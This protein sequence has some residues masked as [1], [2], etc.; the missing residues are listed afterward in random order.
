MNLIG[1][2]ADVKREEIED[3][4][5]IK[6]FG[7]IPADENLALSCLNEGVPVVL[8]NPRHPIAKAYEE[9]AR[10]LVKVIQDMNADYLAK[11]KS[12]STE[13]LKKTS[14]LG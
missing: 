8:K 10:S 5:K 11:M 7:R 3:L 4:L 1:R 12:E 6:I 13:M 14:K 2:K 9:I